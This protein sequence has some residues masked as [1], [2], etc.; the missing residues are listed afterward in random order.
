MVLIASLGLHLLTLATFGTFKVVEAIVR[1]EQ[2]FEAP[3]PIEQ[4]PQ[5]EPEYVVNLEQRNQSSAPLSPTPTT[6]DSPDISLPSLDDIDINVQNV[7]VYRRSPGD[8]ERDGSIREI[9][10]D[11][12]DF[13]GQRMEAGNGIVFAIDMS[14][15]MV[16]EGR[17]KDGYLKVVEEVRKTL[18]KLP[19]GAAFNIIAFAGAVEILKRGGSLESISDRSIASAV[20]WMERRNPGKARLK[21]GKYQW[22]DFRDGKHRGTRTDLALVEAF[23]MAPSTI[24]VLSDGKPSGKT[25]TTQTLQAA[26]EMQKKSK[27]KV[28]INTISYKSSNGRKFLKELAKQNDGEYS[29]IK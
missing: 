24:I 12:I 14:G 20:K 26:S 29:E 8:L 6:V 28:I 7:S 16:E 10:I 13:F 4:V 1:P 27:S 3:P 2:T 21:N 19:K 9:A 25:G 11:S 17:G 22:E 15:S 23:K 18:E 5:Q